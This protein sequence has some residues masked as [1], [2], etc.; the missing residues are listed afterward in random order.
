MKPMILSKDFR[1]TIPH[2]MR[3]QNGWTV[4]AK[5]AYVPSG[6]SIA[7]VPASLAR[8]TVDPAKD[9]TTDDRDRNER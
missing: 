4:G 7:F 5:I 9:P 3:N 8:G 2:E 6:K 1:I